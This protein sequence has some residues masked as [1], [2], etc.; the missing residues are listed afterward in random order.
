MRPVPHSEEVPI[1]E[2][3]ATV[4]LSDSESET[5]EVE[6]DI[7]VPEM[8]DKSPKFFSQEDLNNLVRDLDLTKH[9]SE[10]LASRLKERD[11]TEGDVR[12]TKFRYRS[13]YLQD[14]FAFENNLCYCSDI[15]GLFNELNIPYVANEWRLFIDASLYSTKGVLLHIGNKL[16]SI[17]V[18]HSVVL[19]ETYGNLDFI[20]K[21]I[22]YTEHNWLICADL[23]VVAILSG[24]QL[25]YT[26]YMCFLCKWDSRSR[27]EHYIRKEW[28]MRDEQ[29]IG[30]HNLIQEPLVPKQNIILPPLHIKLGLM[31]QFV[32][33]LDPN[34]PAFAYLR[35]KFPKISEAKIKEGIFVGP[36]IRKLLFDLVFE[37]ALNETEKAA[38]HCFKNVCNSFL[39]KDKSENYEALIDDLIRCY[40]NLGCN[41]SLKV[42]FLHSHLPFFP[43]NLAD[44]SDEH[45]ERFHQDISMVENRYKGK[46]SPAMLADFCWTLHRD[47]SDTVHR[48]KAKYSK[49]I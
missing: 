15:P 16:P 27:K 26:K 18:A 11:L 30:S 5:N 44:V 49:N 32:K 13:D 45:G 21:S 4:V 48:K 37:A 40:R 25:G 33:A 42:H 47:R 9:Q 20:L 39:G 1:P 35:T 7:Y 29:Q 3:P 24:L 28:P 12:I 22:K 38:W 8:Q 14:K 43:E 17:P 23:K 10:L 2:P 31:K 6:D 41:M 46:W 36:Q 34:R 19:K